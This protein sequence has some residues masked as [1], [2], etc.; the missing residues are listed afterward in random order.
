MIRP[1][2]CGVPVLGCGG[3]GPNAVASTG[4]PT[5][6][7]RNGLSKDER[8]ATRLYKLAAV[9]GEA[10][11][12]NNLGVNYRDA[13]GGLSKDEP[14]AARLFKLAADQGNA[15]AQVNLAWMYDNGLGG[16]SK[17][18]RKAARLFKLAADQGNESAKAALS[19]LH[20]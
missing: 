19:N 3:L 16:L 10:T 9:Q 18:Q 12:Q 1:T 14:E 15:Q 6:P 7:R 11:A 13:K 20:H 17:D 2:K 5:P 8:E 4:P